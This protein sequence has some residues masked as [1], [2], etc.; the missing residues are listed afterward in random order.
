MGLV[1]TLYD[2]LLK[3]NM[4]KVIRNLPTTNMRVYSYAL[5]V[6]EALEMSTEELLARM[7]FDY[8]FYTNTDVD[9]STLTAQIHSDYPDMDVTCYKATLKNKVYKEGISLIERRYGIGS[10]VVLRELG[11]K[12]DKYTYKIPNL[13]EFLTQLYPT[14]EIYNLQKEARIL[15]LINNKIDKET[16]NI[17]AYL[18]E[19]GFRK[20]QSGEGQS[21]ATRIAE[22]L[23]QYIYPVRDTPLS[24]EECKYVSE[25]EIHRRDMTRRLLALYPSAVI[26]EEGL[27]QDLVAELA[28]FSTH[29]GLTHQQ[30]LKLWGFKYNPAVA[31]E[32]SIQN[33]A[34][35]RVNPLEVAEEAPA[36]EEMAIPIVQ[37]MVNNQPA[38]LSDIF[39]EC[40]T[41]QTPN[42]QEVYPTRTPLNVLQ[43]LQNALERFPDKELPTGDFEG[44][45]ELVGYLKQ[46]EQQ[47]SYS[48]SD[49]LTFW[50]F[51]VR[52]DAL[53]LRR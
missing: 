16:E 5:F 53:I 51:T 9:V 1:A 45:D 46:I 14:K 24:L 18:L 52:S 11:F 36:A 42:A 37:P 28:T 20:Q 7:G 13:E 26:T 27:P 48:R 10:G 6:A 38:V 8:K 40:L 21:V 2:E 30:T 32:Q 15:S 23:T 35:G 47:T 41:V 33:N 43:T 29:I 3:I 49:I 25:Q 50:G 39:G 4:N 22:E 44:L 17:Y 19:R 31:W 34:L 12:L